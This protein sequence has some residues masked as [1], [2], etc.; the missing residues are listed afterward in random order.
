MRVQE[1]KRGEKRR[2]SSVRR[3]SCVL[4]RIFAM[5]LIP[6]RYVSFHSVGF[7]H[8]HANHVIVNVILFSKVEGFKFLIGVLEVHS[9]SCFVGV[10]MIS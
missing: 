7:V 10:L 1:E 2:G 3:D 4:L 9:K 5:G 6:K 8:P